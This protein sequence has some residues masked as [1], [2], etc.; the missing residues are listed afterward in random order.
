MPALRRLAGANESRSSALVGSTAV[1]AA[2]A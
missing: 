1:I 2:F